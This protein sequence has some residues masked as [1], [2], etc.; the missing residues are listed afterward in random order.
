ML[1]Q[2]GSAQ[3]KVGALELESGL[4]GHCM[5]S[6]ASRTLFTGKRANN[7]GSGGI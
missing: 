1:S 3:F 2:N 4:L 6:M 7:G 5:L